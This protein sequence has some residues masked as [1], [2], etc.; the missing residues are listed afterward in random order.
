[1]DPEFYRTTRH[2]PA[3]AL[4]SVVFRLWDLTT[5]LCACSLH[6]TI[7]KHTTH[8]LRRSAMCF[9]IRGRLL[10]FWPST[11]A[12]LK[13]VD[14]VGLEPTMHGGGRFTVSWGYQ[15]SYTSKYQL[16]DAAEASRLRAGSLPLSL[17]TL[18]NATGSRT[19]LYRMKTC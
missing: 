14:E 15:F 8:F 4:F 18:G 9:N 7:L 19:P 5:T 11:R 17:K 16:Q 10:S 3:S 6:Y 1:M 12:P 13:V 2:S